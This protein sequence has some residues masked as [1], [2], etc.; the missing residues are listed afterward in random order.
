MLFGT[1]PGAP[2]VTVIDWQACRLGPPL[3]DHAIFLAGCMS[4]EDRRATE[5]D[6]LRRYHAGLVANG[7]EGFTFE[8]CLE[9]YRR[10]SLYPFLLA[11]GMSLAISHTDRARQLSAQVLRGAAQLV[12]DLGAA[13]FLD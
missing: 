6:L 8:D 1:V 7:V 2:P 11:V 12:L 3:V 13:E 9:S 5:R 10:S 4:T